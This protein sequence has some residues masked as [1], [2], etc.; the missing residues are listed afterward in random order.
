MVGRFLDVKF[1]P[2]EAHCSKDDLSR[3]VHH[4]ATEWRQYGKDAPH[5]SVL[6]GDEFKPEQIS[7]NIEKFY[8]TGRDHVQDMLNPISRSGFDISRFNR[9]MDFGCGVGR[10][11][12][13][14]APIADRIIG[15]DISPPHLALAK[16]R[17][18]HIEDINVE[19]VSI[20]EVDDILSLGKFNLIISFI[21]LQHNP[22]PV[23]S[24]ILSNLLSSLANGGFAIIQ[25]PT[26]I[27]G[28]KFKTQSYLD[29]PL[30]GIG[31]NPLPQHVIFDVISNGGCDVLEVREDSLLGG[32]SLSHTFC[33]RKRGAALAP[34]TRTVSTR[35]AS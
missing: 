18:T 8:A 32:D 1:T 7:D 17:A 23:I 33:V 31:A 30:P 14:L 28:Y 12:L 2:I 15:V 6:T 3:M 29:N 26:Y 35:P 22:P 10:L 19:F 27:A 24:K 20:N 13:A 11:T 5:W 9:V 16:D 25:V 34:A 21:A 4:I